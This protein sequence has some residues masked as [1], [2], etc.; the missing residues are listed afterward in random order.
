MPTTSSS[1]A[2]ELAHKIETNAARIGVIGLGYVGLPLAHALHRGGLPVV[3]FDVD[4]GKIDAI[5]ENRNYLK[6]LGDSMIQD[7]SGSDR[8]EATT[9]FERLGE[10]DVIL[11]AVPT[12]LG[13]HN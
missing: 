5:A 1:I 13:R 7:L 8:F 4:Q 10:C 9:S 12:P 2:T 6:H 3:G 11:I